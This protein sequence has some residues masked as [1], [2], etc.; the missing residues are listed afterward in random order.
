MAT[1]QNLSGEVFEGG[2][3]L[4]DEAGLM[5]P[6]ALVRPSSEPILPS[7]QLL[8]PSNAT[9]G[10][11]TTGDLSG[12]DEV[13]ALETPLSRSVSAPN[14]DNGEDGEFMGGDGLPCRQQR[15]S[16]IAG[17]TSRR[18]GWGN[19]D[20]LRRASVAALATRNRQGRYRQSLVEFPAYKTVDRFDP[21]EMGAYEVLKPVT[22]LLVKRYD[23]T[24]D[25]RHVL[26]KVKAARFSR[27][28][29]E[30]LQALTVEELADERFVLTLD[31][32]EYL[33]APSQ[34][35]RFLLRTG[36]S[37][38]FYD[39]NGVKTNC[40]TPRFPT[41]IDDRDVVASVLLVP[42]LTTANAKSSHY[43]V[44]D[45]AHSLPMQK[46]QFE[47]YG[48]KYNHIGIACQNS[49]RFFHDSEPMG[50][51]RLAKQ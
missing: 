39:A 43:L 47:V 17:A 6:A 50:R 1:A 40:K 22:D 16:L 18:Q 29:R 36:S 28:D 11:A 35:G 4:R 30:K 41:L 32:G 26:D 19:R 3:L 33:A 37:G 20:G 46:N 24:A 5:P 25:M 10:L 51:R 12:V 34:V 38:R 45:R 31:A 13:K 21:A 27:R 8:L 48:P 7:A 42:G 14:L 49:G 44:L 23:S 2:E 9:F 15:S